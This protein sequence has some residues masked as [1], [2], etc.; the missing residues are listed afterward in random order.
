MFS[1]DHTISAPARR[2]DN[3]KFFKTGLGIGEHL[4]TLKNLIM[5]NHHEASTIDY[6]KVK[7]F[8]VVI[9]SNIFHQIDIEG[10]E[11]SSGGFLDWISSGALETVSQLA[12]ELHIPD[13]PD[14]DRQ[15]IDLLRILQDL[16]RLGYR[17]ISQ[18]VNM[19][20]G[21]DR[22]GFY[23]FLEVVFMK[24]NLSKLSNK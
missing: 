7:I 11:F 1:Y 21:P 2:G 3:I 9:L 18:E 13:N 10:Y 4:E 17:V 14:N 6:I 15:Y 23:N 20:M 16:Y 24:E 22:N 19:V 5:K 8:Q 12:L